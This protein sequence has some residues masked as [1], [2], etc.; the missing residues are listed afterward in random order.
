MR[1]KAIVGSCFYSNS[2][3]FRPYEKERVINFRVRVEMEN[4]KCAIELIILHITI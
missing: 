1:F 4:E 3:A 2:D